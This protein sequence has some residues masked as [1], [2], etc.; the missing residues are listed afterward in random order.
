[1]SDGHLHRVQAGAGGVPEGVWVGV[2]GSG[3]CE[4][5]GGGG[6][7][8]HREGGCQPPSVVGPGGTVRLM[9][10]VVRWG[11]LSMR[12]WRGLLAGATQGISG[13]VCNQAQ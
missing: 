10:W 2:V 11:K 4:G 1:M 5:G 3:K 7:A 13:D 9:A 8:E 6:R 12:S